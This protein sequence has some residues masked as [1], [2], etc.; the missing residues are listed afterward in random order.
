MFRDLL[1]RRRMNNKIRRSTADQRR[2]ALPSADNGDKISNPGSHNETLR[3][4]INAAIEGFPDS[5]PPLLLLLLLSNRL[6]ASQLVMMYKVGSDVMKQCGGEALSFSFRTAMHSAASRSGLGAT[7]KCYGDALGDALCVAVSHATNTVDLHNI[8][9]LYRSLRQ[10]EKSADA[11]RRHLAQIEDKAGGD[12]PTSIAPLCF[13]AFVQYEQK[14]YAGEEATLQK[15]LKITLARD[16]REVHASQLTVD[17]LDAISE[18]DAL[19]A[20]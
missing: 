3:F 16:R 5:H 19:C 1:R 4:L 2:G 12:S 8:A 14:D 20:S 9:R 18:L 6:T 13:L 17:G 15:I 11:V 10:Y 7:I